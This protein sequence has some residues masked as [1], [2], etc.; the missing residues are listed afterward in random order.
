[1]LS[2]TALVYLL[3]LATSLGCAA[4]LV[5]SYAGNRTRLLLWTAVCFGFLALNNLL[6]VIDILLLPQADLLPFRHAAAL[7]AVSVLLFAFIWE[8]D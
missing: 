7:A 1:M 4:L 5:R 8:A 3:C 2:V 6:V